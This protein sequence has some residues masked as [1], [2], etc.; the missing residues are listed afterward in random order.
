[1][2]NVGEMNTRIDIL[3]YIKNEDKYGYIFNRKLWAKKIDSGKSIVYSKYSQNTKEMRF[4]IRKSN[5]DNR[6][7]IKCG[8]KHY[9]IV[10]ILPYKSQINFLEIIC[11]EVELIECTALKSLT[12]FNNELNRPTREE[13]ENI[14]FS[15]FISEKYTMYTQ[16]SKGDTHNEIE[17]QFMLVVPNVLKL[18]NGEV[19]YINQVG[20]VIKAIHLYISEYF[21]YEIYKKEDV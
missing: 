4:I 7:L 18:S 10:D 9:F 8:E 3:E 12:S 13:H 21:T 20:Y 19:V 6:N 15:G 17:M 14:V 1:M 11:G 2:I 16:L 5:I